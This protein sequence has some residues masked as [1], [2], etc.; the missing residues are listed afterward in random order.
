MNPSSPEPSP[1]PSRRLSTISHDLRYPDSQFVRVK[2]MDVHYRDVGEGPV[3]VLLHGMFASL[4]TWEA[5][6]DT[7]KSDFRVIALDNPNYGLTGLH[8]EAMYPGIYTDFME[9]FLDELNISDCM[10]AGNSLGGWITWEFAAKHPQRVTKL[11][12]IDSAGYLFFPTVT[13]SLLGMPLAVFANRYIKAPRFFIRR[14]L[15]SVYGNPAL[16]DEDTVDLYHRLMSL[17]GNLV[18]ATRVVHFIRNQMGFR[19]GQIKAIQQPTLVMWGEKD[20]WIPKRHV[21]S[22]CRDLP[23]ATAVMYPELGHV[24]QEEAPE[25]SVK[26]ARDF[27]LK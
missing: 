2:G 5:W 16:L 13:L 20:R 18:A 27:L 21:R 26:D 24:P 14:V 3:L 17:P 12:L 10:M 1:I 19:N 7:L 9:A 8:P 23:N 22:F 25:I 4:H 11:I 6:I 15:K